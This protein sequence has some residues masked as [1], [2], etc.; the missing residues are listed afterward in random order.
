[1]DPDY[2]ID[3]LWKLADT[4]TITQAAA[5]VAGYEPNEVRFNAYGD[6][7][8]ENEHGT[9]DSAGGHSVKTAFEAIKNAIFSGKLKGKIVHDSRPIEQADDR[10]LFDMRECCG[11]NSANYDTLCS[12]DEHVYDHYFVK[13]APNLEKSFVTVDDLR[14]W[15]LSKGSR[16]GFLFP[17]K[18][19][20]PD[21]FDKDNP[22]YAPKLAAS[23][24]AWE[25]VST[26]QKYKDNG[27]TV[28]KNLENWLTAH[29]ADFGL[30]KDDGEINNDAIVNQASKVANW[31]DKGGASKT[32]T[33]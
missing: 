17:E 5:L 1:M 13:N 29:A 27:K 23:I 22:C 14:V 24:R 4:L 19:L 25:A 3:P 26:E 8:F 21:Y 9:T 33:R 32:P 28:K 2:Y 7:Y 30:L 31:D 11:Y 15:L 18:N 10:A 16:T 12:D 6:V 20:E